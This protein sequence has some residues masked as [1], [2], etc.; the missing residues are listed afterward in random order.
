[1]KQIVNALILTL[2]LCTGISALAEN[3][4]PLEQSKPCNPDLIK[5]P[6]PR[7]GDPF[8]WFFPL[9]IPWNEIEG[10]WKTQGDV[11]IF[12]EVK[13]IGMNAKGARYVQ[14]Q[15]YSDVSQA[16]IAKGIGFVPKK[17]RIL[18]AMVTGPKVNGRIRVAS[19]AFPTQGCAKFRA[20]TAA[21]VTLYD[22]YGKLLLDEVVLMK[23][24]PTT[25]R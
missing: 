6:A 9:E 21:Q 20:Q 2:A 4:L 5:Q 1:M 19:I 16:P 10:T 14:V 3:Q 25:P 22:K 13:V 8:P 11:T 7:E 12:I 15:S 17:E 18:E 24:V 23:K